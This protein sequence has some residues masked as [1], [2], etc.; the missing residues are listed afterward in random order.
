MSTETIRIDSMTPVIARDWTRRAI[1][2]GTGPF[3]PGWTSPRCIVALTVPAEFGEL[4]TVVYLCMDMTWRVQDAC[5][6]AQTVRLPEGVELDASNFTARTVC[7][8]PL[9]R[10][11][12]S[13]RHTPPPCGTLECEGLRE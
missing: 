1:D 13:D 4:P 7:G 10:P 8:Q 9:A 2:D 3:I 11:T 5:Y 12:I 6:M